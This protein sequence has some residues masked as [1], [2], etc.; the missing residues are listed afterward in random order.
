MDKSSAS[1]IEDTAAEKPHQDLEAATPRLS[2]STISDVKDSKLED[3]AQKTLRRHIND[4][5]PTP[6]ELRQ[7]RWKIDLFLVRATLRQST[8]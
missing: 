1:N 5:P 6:E 3:V 2:E 7:V 4:A 8:G